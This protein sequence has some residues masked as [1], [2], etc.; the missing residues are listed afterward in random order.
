[1]G[2]E[3]LPEGQEGSGGQSAGPGVDVTTSQRAGRECDALP[4]GQEWLGGPQ[5]GPTP[6]QVTYK[7]W[8]ALL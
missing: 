3:A 6:S 2:R 1:M 8:E 4:W 7:S 5:R